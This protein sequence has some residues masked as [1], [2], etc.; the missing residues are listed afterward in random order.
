MCKE[1]LL[2]MLKECTKFLMKIDL[3]K[4]KFPSIEFR[5]IRGDMLQVFK[6]AKKYYDCCSTESLFSSIVIIDYVDTITN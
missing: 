1:D 4:L 2:S 5:Q 6:I 3:K